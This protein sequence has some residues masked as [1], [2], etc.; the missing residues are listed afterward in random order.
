VRLFAETGMEMMVACSF[1]KNF[2]L[3]GERVGALH[4]VAASPEHIPC[5]ASQLRVISRSLY[6]NCPTFGARVVAII[7][8]DKERSAAWEKECAAMANRISD[9]RHMLYDALVQSDA[10]GDWSHVTN[11]RGMF[12]Y[13]GLNAEAVARLKSEFHI[14]M[15]ANGRISMAGLNTKNISRFASAIAA[16]VGTNA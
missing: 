10:R 5:I 6:S 4:F 16:I 13:T 7:L 14:Y 3:Y 12:S 15:L 9:V 2:G 11:Q 8:G 1:S